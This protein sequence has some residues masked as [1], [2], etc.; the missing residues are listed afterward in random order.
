MAAKEA[1]KQAMMVLVVVRRS[2]SSKR[3][4][5]RGLACILFPVVHLLQE[6]LRLLL[7]DEGQAGLALFQL[8][9]MEKDAVLVIAPVFVDF[10]VPY[11]SSVCGLPAS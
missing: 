8:K 10:L 4:L 11:Y 9:G 1:S 7:V 2:S 6:L 3:R 5:Q